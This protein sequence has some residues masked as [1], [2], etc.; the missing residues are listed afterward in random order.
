[1]F[2]LIENKYPKFHKTRPRVAKY[3]G[4]SK[5]LFKAAKMIAFRRVLSS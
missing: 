1:M 3:D 5:Q 2:P 4:N